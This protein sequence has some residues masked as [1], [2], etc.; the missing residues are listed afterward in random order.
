MVSMPILYVILIIIILYIITHL[1]WFSPHGENIILNRYISAVAV[2]GTLVA[3]FSF[4]QS[5]NDASQNAKISLNKELVEADEKAFIDIEEFFIQHYPYNFNLYKQLYSNDPELQNMHVYIDDPVRE[6]ITELRTCKI[7]LKRM[8][9]I[10][11]IFGKDNWINN[12]KTKPWL[13][14]FVSWFKSPI[15]RSTWSKLKQYHSDSFRKFIDQYVI[16]LSNSNTN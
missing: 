4:Y 1:Y 5:Y 6:K 14:L 2:V 8:E 15:L 11:Y 16:P 10:Y 9:T 13:T 12:E 7:L 3:I